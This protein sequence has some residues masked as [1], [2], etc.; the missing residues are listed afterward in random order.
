VKYKLSKYITSECYSD[1]LMPHPLCYE[2]G[3]LTTGFRR[4]LK[5]SAFLLDKRLVTDFILNDVLLALYT[6]GEDDQADS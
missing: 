2:R 3:F 6:T 5:P 1:T 4:P